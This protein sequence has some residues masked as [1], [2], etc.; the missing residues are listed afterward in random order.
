MV[1]LASSGR[2]R[3]ASMNFCVFSARKPTSRP[4]RSSSM[5]V[6]PPEVPI[7]WMAGGEKENAIPCGSRPSSRLRRAWMPATCSSGRFRSDHGFRAMK[8][9]PL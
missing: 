5:K 2:F 7:P 6:T 3:A 9:K 1:T 8:K 4:A